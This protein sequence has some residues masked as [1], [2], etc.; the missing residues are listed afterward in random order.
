MANQS[1]LHLSPGD[2]SGNKQ[3]TTTI[4]ETIIPCTQSESPQAANAWKVLFL[5]FLA[6][7]LN[8]FDRTIPAIVVEPI[9]LEWGL[10]D[11]QLGLIAGAFTLVYAVA[12]I[13]LGRLADR[14]SRKKIMAWGLVVWSGFTALNAVAWNYVSFFMVRMGVGV[15]E[16]SYA[17]A[18]NSLISDLFPPEKRSR[19]TGI[20]MLGLPLGLVLAFFTVGAMIT[21]FDSW[22]APFLIAAVPGIILAIA[23]FFIKEPERG[24]SEQRKLADD[25]VANPIRKL[26]KIPTFFWII[27]SGVTINFAAYAGNGFLVPLLQR[28]FEIS[29]TQAALCTG[30]IVGITGLIGLTAGGWLADKG[31]Q[32]SPRGRLSVGAVSLVIA[33]LATAGALYFSNHS[34]VA[35]VVLFG[36]GWLAH[37]N[38]Y[39]SVYPTIH[40][41]VE[42]RLRSTAIA[43]YFAGMYLLGGA[44]GPIVVGAL[45]DQ[46]A[47]YHMTLAGQ[48]EMTEVFK[49]QGLYDAMY[50]IP[51]AL[52]LTGL[53]IWQASRHII[54]DKEIR[55]PG[56]SA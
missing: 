21:A 33:A 40:D 24:Q 29:L 26:L 39:T 15:G 38:Y 8:F 54:A 19:A 3:S 20:F 52:L 14:I 12:G 47:Q 48:S 44:F 34:L 35:F 41:I 28:Y 16:A 55:T 1:E 6:N 56:Q 45:S 13:P 11:L 51:V 36:F 31:H 49:A 18:A 5:L 30:V 10:S 53:F 2:L 43:V 42:P 50:L 23:M 22:R 9:R 27:L 7:L 46:L 4:P 37:Y 25:V 17:P 32:F